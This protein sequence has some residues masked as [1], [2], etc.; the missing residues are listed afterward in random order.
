MVAVAC[1][2]A[3]AL[4]CTFFKLYF[5]N[6]YQGAMCEEKSSFITATPQSCY[7]GCERIERYVRYRLC[8]EREPVK[9]CVMLSF[10]GKCNGN[11][12]G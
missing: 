12:T 9:A 10:T 4:H 11:T 8:C 6:D 1:F 5:A 2:K 3:S 7:E